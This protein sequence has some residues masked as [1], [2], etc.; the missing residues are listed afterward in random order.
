VV[1][2]ASRLESMTKQLRVP[3]VIDEAT[4]AIVNARLDRREGRTRRLAKVLP[5]GIETPVLVSELL[6][7]ASAEGVLTDEQVAF[8]DQAV[9]HFIDGRWEDAYQDLHRMPASDRAQDFLGVVIAQHNRVP[10]TG[11]NGVLE[12]PNK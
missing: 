8:F 1:N 10:P 2:L 4:A 9:G 3:I 12:L 6:P 5:Y 7:P 11:W